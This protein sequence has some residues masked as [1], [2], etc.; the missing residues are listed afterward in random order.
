MVNL[1]FFLAGFILAGIIAFFVFKQQQKYA[2]AQLDL[3]AERFESTSQRMI[4]ERSEALTQANSEHIGNL[5]NPLK[6]EMEN[7]RKL[8]NDTRSANEKS[9][10]SLEGKL[11][12]MMKQTTQISKDATNLADALKNRGK[13]H[14]DWG[15]QVLEDILTGSGLIKDKEFTTQESFKGENGNELRPD[16]VINLSDGKR[17]VVDS[18]ASITA[19]TD[20][21]GADN[22]V[23]QEQ[24]I[25]SH[26]ESVKKHV[27]ELAAKQYPKYVDGSLQY[28]LMF[29]PN[30]GAYV[31]AMNYHN[32]LAQEAFRKGIVIVNP[33]NLML[34]LNLVW[35]TW[36]NLRQE[37]NCKEI[38]RVATNLH[39][40]VVG[41]VDTCT[42]LGNQLSTAQR[43][44]DTL[45]NQVC[46]GTG[47]LLGRVEGMRALGVASPKR[48][49]VKS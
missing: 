48:P 35:Q 22:T 34:V 2:Q 37:D 49:K 9:N 23:E 28:V 20:A 36:Q 46:T 5:L 24:L 8:M 1:L 47:N 16:V 27:D 11:E 4:K 12:E 3:L 45:N 19:Y 17:I 40:K 10:S 6:M 44:F 18:K 13:V 33:T 39:D 29:I 14:G 43:T 26:Y 30:E 15:E 31:M 41:I 42:T 32:G 21:L 25:R 38:L 7:V